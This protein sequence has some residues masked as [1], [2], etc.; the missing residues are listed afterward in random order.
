MSRSWL[1]SKRSQGARRSLYHVSFSASA[2]KN[3]WMKSRNEDCSE[4]VPSELKAEQM[5]FPF[6]VK[7]VVLTS[8]RMHVCSIWLIIASPSL[9]PAYLHP[10]NPVLFPP[11]LLHMHNINSNGRPRAM[12]PWQPFAARPIFT[13]PTQSWHGCL[14]AS[15]LSGKQTKALPCSDWCSG[16]GIV[17]QAAGVPL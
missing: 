6:S 11:S 15:Q 8:K 10:N 4:D 5:S 13:G 1:I 2:D 12:L 3:L 14:G 16:T 7:D 9:K 17:C